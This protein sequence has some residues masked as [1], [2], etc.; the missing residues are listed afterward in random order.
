M[1]I[2]ER[3][4]PTFCF[5]IRQT[6]SLF[7]DEVE[8]RAEGSAEC[9]LHYKFRYSASKDYDYS[10]VFVR[11]NI[12]SERFTA[13]KFTY[14]EI[15]ATDYSEKYGLCVTFWHKGNNVLNM[16]SPLNFLPI[17]VLPDLLDSKV[18]TLTD[19]QKTALNKMLK[20][21]ATKWKKELFQ[22]S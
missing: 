10:K 5:S 21:F 3:F 11:E 8:T 1:I 14:V 22:L 7:L 4:H 19:K 20:Y 16:A 9:H 15:S 17:S 6:N 2:F 18:L 13:R 12:V